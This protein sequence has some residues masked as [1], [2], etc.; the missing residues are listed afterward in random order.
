M[1]SDKA[2]ELDAA[3]GSH[4]VQ[5]RETQGEESDKFLSYFRPCVIPVQSQSPPH[6]VGSGHKSSR[7]TMFRCEGEHV[8]RVTEVRTAIP[9]FSFISQFCWI[10]DVRQPAVFLMLSK[11]PFS[12]SSLSHKGVFIV[13]TASKIFFFSGCN[14]SVQT[15]AKSLD[16]VKHL[17]ENRHSG[18]CEIAEIGT[19]IYSCFLHKCG[20]GKVITLLLLFFTS[21]WL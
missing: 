13:D 4:T 8:A 3:L 7:T 20:G 21:K 2:V 10:S 11:V 16:V 1:A 17:K 15:R 14:S 5:Y 18:R 6:M 9:K 12:R 19:P